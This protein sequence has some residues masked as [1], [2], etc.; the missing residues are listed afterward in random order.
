MIAKFNIMFS[1]IP[2]LSLPNKTLLLT[3]LLCILTP[4]WANNSNPYIV[5]NGD[6]L[7]SIAQQFGIRFS[8]IDEIAA[9]NNIKKKDLIFPGQ[10]I[11]LGHFLLTETA[12]SDIPHSQDQAEIIPP[13]IELEIESIPAKL[14]EESEQKPVEIVE[15]TAAETEESPTEEVS[16]PVSAEVKPK[17]RFDFTFDPSFD[18]GFGVGQSRVDI[19]A[20]NFSAAEQNFNIDMD[21]QSLHLQLF[22]IMSLNQT[23]GLEL[24]LHSLGEYEFSGELNSNL[25]I[26]T[27]QGEQKYQALS[28]SAHYKKRISFFDTRFSAGLMQIKQSTFGSIDTLGNAPVPLSNDEN[29]SNPFIALE[30]HK[31]V[32]NDWSFGPIF[33]WVD[34][35]DPIQ[36]LS[37]RLSRPLR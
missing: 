25:N 26:G 12:K 9:L 14:S 13:T 21:E 33:T 37:L 27:T 16:Q 10:E 5:K 32:Y 7:S 29:S 30:A 11:Y 35:G 3:V 2:K 22:L 15:E 6:S 34:T 36:S 24:A 4:V 28:L 20:S 23:V 1:C 19:G 17:R 8:K 31:K 18:L